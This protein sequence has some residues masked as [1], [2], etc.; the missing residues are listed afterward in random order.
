ME[1]GLKKKK[2]IYIYIYIY[3]YKSKVTVHQGSTGHGE[4]QIGLKLV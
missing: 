1:S 4:C 2:I 3:I